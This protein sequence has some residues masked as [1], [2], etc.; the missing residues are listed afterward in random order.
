[1]TGM[2]LSTAAI[3]ALAMGSGMHAT[4]GIDRQPRPL[5]VLVFTKTGG[6]RHDSI[7]AGREA[8]GAIAKSEGHTVEYTE[9]SSWFATE[10][11]SR[12]DVVVFLNTTGDILN[13]AQEKAFEEYVQ[14]GGGYVGL[15]AAADTEYE[16]EWYG[17]LVGAYFA[18]HPQIQKGTI[19]VEDRQHPITRHL[20]AEWVRTDE[21]YN[22]RS[23]P[24]GKARVLAT[25]DESTY[26]GGTM[27]A[28][29][30]IAWCQEIGA[31]RAFYTGCGHTKE[32]YSEPEFV[33][34]LSA[35]LQWAARR[36]LRP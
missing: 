34:M 30:P 18:G 33:K 9:D 10:K 36:P 12:F 7:P 8:I 13:A 28:D 2:I 32:T 27:G 20:P 4:F 22:Y 16:W 29:H 24:R 1:M 31:G 35:A 23:N 19:R 6:Y 14:S 3:A 11:L 21:W 17:K 15:H 25:L 5:S 26:Q